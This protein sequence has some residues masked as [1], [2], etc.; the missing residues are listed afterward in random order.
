[1]PA[2]GLRALGAQSGQAA[3]AH[4]LPCDEDGRGARGQQIGDG[5]GEVQGIEA[6]EPRGQ[7]G[8]HLGHEVQQRHKEQD[9]PRQREEHRL[10]RLACGLEVVGAHDLKAHKGQNEEL[11]SE[12]EGGEVHEPVVLD[13]EAV[14]DGDGE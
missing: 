14:G 13:A 2:S 9:L 6:R 1:M 8:Q 5:S 10:G 4:H 7:R 12:G 11:H 3:Q